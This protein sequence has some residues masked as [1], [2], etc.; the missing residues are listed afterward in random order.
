MMNYTG[1]PAPSYPNYNAM[2][3]GQQEKAEKYWQ[4]I[5]EIWR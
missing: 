3:M 4:K 1:Y 2:N 5:T